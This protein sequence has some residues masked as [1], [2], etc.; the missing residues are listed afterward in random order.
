MVKV[1]VEGKKITSEEKLHDILQEKLGL[2]DYY[3]RNLDALWDFLTGWV[4]LP[5]TIEWV[6]HEES[7]KLLG[8]YYDKLLAVLR[9]AERE[10]KGFK[11]ELT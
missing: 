3:G 11:I 1:T 5:L 10:L 4:D 8:D 7:K 9:D 2:P 6:N